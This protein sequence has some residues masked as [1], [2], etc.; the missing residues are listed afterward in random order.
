MHMSMWPTLEAKS[1]EA[2]YALGNHIHVSS[3]KQHKW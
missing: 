1:Y 2:M 3:A